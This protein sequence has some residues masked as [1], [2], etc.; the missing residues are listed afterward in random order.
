MPQTGDID[1]MRLFEKW[2]DNGTKTFCILWCPDTLYAASCAFTTT[3]QRRVRTDAMTDRSGSLG[4][5]LTMRTGGMIDDA[6]RA[7]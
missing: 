4:S 1:I 7:A 5:A 3:A 6:K 2:W